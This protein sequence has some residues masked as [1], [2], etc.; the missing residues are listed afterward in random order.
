MQMYDGKTTI[1]TKS[2]WSDVCTTENKFLKTNWILTP[3]ATGVYLL[4]KH[5][6]MHR[7]M[8]R[9]QRQELALQ[10][11]T[12][13]ATACCRTQ[14]QS[15]APVLWER[16]TCMVHWNPASMGT[17]G[18]SPPVKS[19]AW[20]PSPTPG[21][22]KVFRK[23]VG[24]N[25]REAPPPSLTRRRAMRCPQR[26]HTRRP[27]PPQP[28]GSPKGLEGLKRRDGP[29]TAWGTRR[30]TTSRPLPRR[31]GPPFPPQPAEAEA[32]PGAAAQGEARSPA[33]PGPGPRQ[34]RY[35]PHEPRPSPGQAPPAGQPLPVA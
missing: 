8:R 14:N 29:G 10:L 12:M 27:G 6:I 3:M 23:P 2:A 15:E 21:T 35:P 24:I 5:Q 4:R 13:Q 7:Y 34:P 25:T 31:H 32:Q 19:L 20:L 1:S 16:R 17:Q 26:K 30:L 28:T 18:S 33:G 9:T 11:L 22:G